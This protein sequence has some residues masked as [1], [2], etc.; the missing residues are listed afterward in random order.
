MSI[1]GLS[2]K[3]SL[4]KLTAQLLSSAAKEKTQMTPAIQYRN[5]SRF[6]LLPLD[7]DRRGNGSG[8]NKERRQK[9]KRS[10]GEFVSAGWGR[11]D[12]I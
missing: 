6:M 3:S 9:K 1:A 8:Y 11:A 10:T 2:K 12:Q 4:P 7:P 5:A